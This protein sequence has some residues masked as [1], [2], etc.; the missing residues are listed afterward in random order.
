VLL[1]V[2]QIKKAV[3]GGEYKLN[4]EELGNGEIRM[5]RAFLEYNERQL[6]ELEDSDCP[7]IILINKYKSNIKYYE[8]KLKKLLK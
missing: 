8:K 4:K 3:N 6:R 5:T 2:Y 1:L 7:D